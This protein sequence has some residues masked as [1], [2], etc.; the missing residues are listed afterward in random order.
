LLVLIRPYWSRFGVVAFLGIVIGLLGLLAPYL[1]KTFVDDVYPSRDFDLLGILVIGIA[2]FTVAS[3]LMTSLRSYYTQVMTAQLGR[4][5]SLLYFNHLQHL[6]IRFFDRHR[7]GEVMSRYG[8]LRAS[9]GSVA[10]VLQVVLVNGVFLVVIPPVLFAMNWR[11]AL[12]ALCTTPLTT[13]LTVGTARFVRNWWKRAAE[14]SAES[15]AFQL[16]VLSQIRSVKSFGAEDVIFASVARQSED[17]LSMQLRSTGVSALAALVSGAIRAVGSAVFTWY[18]WAAIINS[19]LTL[20]AFLAF[21]A[22][23]GFLMAPVGQ[24]TGLFASFQRFSVTLVRAF[25]YLDETPE[26]DTVRAF[27]RFPAIKRRATG[28]IG[29]Q[30]VS[31]SYE[32]DRPVLRDLTLHLASGSVHAVVGPSGAGKSTILRL[33]AR[34]EDP[35][36][37]TITI[38]GESL[39]RFS[40]PDLRRQVAVVWQ[41][42]PLMRGTLWENLT[43]GVE[44]TKEEAEDAL[45]ACQL[46]TFMQDLPD[47]FE[48]PVAEWGA[49]LSG[50]QR[51]RLAIARALVR[52]TP[53]LLLDE[54]TSQMDVH[55][56]RELLREV[57]I[58]ARDRTVIMVTHRPGTASLADR[59]LV[60]EGGQLTGAGTHT[61]LIVNHAWYSGLAAQGGSEEPRYLRILAGQG[62]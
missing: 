43:L 29:F 30:N 24:M 18:A 20:G 7:V 13:A 53:I 27:A 5:V 12:L 58:A 51:Q 62:S 54:A 39:Q 49:S 36:A 6:P 35:D 15:S 42:F 45:H 50:G 17:A 46:A 48:T 44:V 47:G 34:F 22:Y 21:T 4:A 16:E 55:T 40:L 14:I 19:E 38:D 28:D 8:D 56:E 26:Q 31:F 11:L 23:L 60:I 2:T 3:T 33:L 59:V 25:E 57:M 1:T 37:G 41:D 9:L 10:N 32:T 52:R 61:D